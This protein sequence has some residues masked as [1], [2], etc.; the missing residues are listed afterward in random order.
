MTEEQKVLQIN[1]EVEKAAISTAL[2]KAN[3]AK[4]GL[5]SVPYL[6]S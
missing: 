1:Q 3:M 6:Q 4:W 2:E 5:N